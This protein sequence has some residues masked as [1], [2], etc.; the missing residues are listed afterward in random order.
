MV[1]AII[2]MTLPLLIGIIITLFVPTKRQCKAL[3]LHNI[4]NRQRVPHSLSEIS[5]KKLRSLCLI[6]T[7]NNVRL[8]SIQKSLKGEKSIPLT[9]DD[10]F[11]SVYEKALPILQEHSFSATIYVTTA[12]LSNQKSKDVYSHPKMSTEMLLELHQKGFEIGSHTVTHRALT[13][14][15]DDEVKEELRE[16][17]RIIERIVQAPVTSLAFPL[18]LWNERVL[19]LAKECGYV[20]FSAYNYHNKIGERPEITPVTAIYPF[21]SEYDMRVKLVDGSLRSQSLLRSRIIPHFAKGSPLA[22][23]SEAYNPLRFFDRFHL[24]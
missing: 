12:H 7:N 9:F 14:L 8:T 6:A 10:G 11:I 24:L 15:S 21:D 17:K 3:L 19:K 18:G 22:S 1:I 16:S 4:Y 2:S 13:L 20:H 5:E 23:F